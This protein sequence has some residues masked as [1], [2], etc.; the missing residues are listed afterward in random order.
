MGK[1][2]VASV[3]VLGKKCAQCRSLGGVPVWG[4]WERGA[5]VCVYLGGA[6]EVFLKANFQ[7]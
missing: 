5:P 2:N 4:T 6:P 7:S 3:G 1:K